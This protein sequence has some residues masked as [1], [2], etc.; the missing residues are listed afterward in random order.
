MKKLY[1]ILWLLI[2]MSFG[3]GVA[4]FLDAQFGAVRAYK[5]QAAEAARARRHQPPYAA[6]DG[7]IVNVS[8][9]L[10]SIEYVDED[11]LRLIALQSVHFQKGSLIGNLAGRKIAQTPHNV[12][13]F[14]NEDRWE[15]SV[16]EEGV[17][18]VVDFPGATY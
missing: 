12:L 1:L 15:I 6:I 10:L 9:R 11:R 16:L 14:R 3:R 8:Y 5:E 18:E 2:F 4:D 17:T 7:R 13:M